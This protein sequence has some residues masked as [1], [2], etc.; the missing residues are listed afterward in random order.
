[1]TQLDTLRAQR[2]DAE[3]QFQAVM[4]MISMGRVES[5][6]IAQALGYHREVSATFNA[7]L[8]LISDGKLPNHHALAGAATT[9]P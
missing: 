1:V 9:H 2:A 4:E 8:S 3:E 5:E 6:I 7:E